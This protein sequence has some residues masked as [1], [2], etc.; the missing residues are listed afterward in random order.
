MIK[1]KLQVHGNRS[2]Y[3]EVLPFFCFRPMKDHNYLAQDPEHLHQF[4]PHIHLASQGDA[5]KCI[6]DMRFLMSII[7]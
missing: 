5:R 2:M 6:G 7:S 4:A 1:I 3:W